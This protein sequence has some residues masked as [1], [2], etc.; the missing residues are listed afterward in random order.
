M[1]SHSLNS[2]VTYQ[3]HWM[4]RRVHRP[5]G[6]KVFF[7]F[8]FVFK[9]IDVCAIL[10]DPFMRLQVPTN[11]Q[12]GIMEGKR[13][14]DNGI[15]NECRST[16][17]VFVEVLHKWPV[18]P[19]KKK[20]ITD[21][22]P[23]HL[24]QNYSGS[25]YKPSHCARWPHGKGL[26]PGNI[27]EVKSSRSSRSKARRMSASYGADGKL[28]FYTLLPFLYIPALLSISWPAVT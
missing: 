27:H 20:K 22:L 5:L 16:A 23:A 7:L 11:E 13:R 14:Y 9:Y 8:C 3:W 17:A 12:G 28:N 6:I 2:S 10:C 18:Y 1:S 4:S 15:W 25:N 21:S 26:F 24:C 19:L